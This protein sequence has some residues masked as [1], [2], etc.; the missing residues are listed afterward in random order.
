M[1]KKHKFRSKIRWHL[2]PKK[3][4]MYAFIFFLLHIT[5]QHVFLMI[6]YN[7]KLQN[8]DN[9]LYPGKSATPTFFTLLY[10]LFS[11]PFVTIFS[12]L[13]ISNNIAWVPFVLNS[14]VWTL[15]V[16]ITLSKLYKKHGIR[17]D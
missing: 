5:L 13:T 12:N 14:L 3:V 10:T 8:I 15:V 17:K 4:H 11:F 6:S 2:T 9:L 1:I 16:H 7:V